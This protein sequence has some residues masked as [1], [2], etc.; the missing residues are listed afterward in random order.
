MAIGI[1]EE[2]KRANEALQKSEKSYRL[3]AENVTDV[4]WSIDMNMK[5]VYIS[6]SNTLMTGFSNDEALALRLEDI[7][8]PSSFRAVKQILADEFEIEKMP[9]KD[10]SRSR[11]VEV[12]EYCKN[13]RTIWVEIKATF[14]RDQ[15]GQ[16]IGIQGV[17]RDITDRKQMEEALKKSEQEKAA[18]LGGLKNGAVEYL[19]PQMRIIWVNEAV[20]KSLGLSIKDM[21]GK[22]CF[23]LIEGLKTPC[24]G[25]TAVIACK[26]GKPY[27]KELVTPDG[28]TWISCS[29]PLKDS[30]GQVTG[31]VH[32]AINIT[33][34]KRAEEAL[35]ESE[36][37]YRAIFE[38]TG[39]STV[40]LEEDTT[41]SLANEEFEKLTGYTKDEIEGKKTWTDFAVKD[42]LEKMMNQHRLR[43]ENP[44]TALKTYEFRLRDKSSQIKDIL[45]T[46]DMIS[47]T[48]KSVA[49]LLD[50]SERKR[51]EEEL[52]WNAAL[53]EA[54]V[55][56]SLDGILVVDGQGKRII[57]NQRLLDLWDVPQSIIDQEKDEALLE[58]VVALTR[59]PRPIP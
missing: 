42:D 24:P 50:I 46:V 47:G 6:P 29:N 16:P 8:T 9:L 25:C 48:R 2:R 45:L 13:G 14:L 59:E 34:R 55:E 10:L 18:I 53:L 19:D 52:R 17:S 22:Y 7:L 31:V 38:N 3:L 23:E 11:T 12:E 41:I 40:I 15:E 54:Q 49:S 21:Q 1:E 5:F 44:G 33:G 28:K 26:T 4:I 32:V 39:T 58:Y 20:Q 37:K 35:K 43:R 57:T 36:N 27:E 56:S 30:T 51:A